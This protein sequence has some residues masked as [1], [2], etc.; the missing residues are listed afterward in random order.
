MKLDLQKSN[1]STKSFTL[2]SNSK[3]KN[4]EIIVNCLGLEQSKIRREKTPNSSLIKNEEKN[5]DEKKI[6]KT[7][8]KSNSNSNVKENDLKFRNKSADTNSR[9][10]FVLFNKSNVGNLKKEIDRYESKNTL[11]NNL[12][13]FSD[14]C[15]EKKTGNF[16]KKINKKEDNISI[17]KIKNFE[18]NE[19]KKNRYIISTDV[20]NKDELDFSR[21]NNLPKCIINLNDSKTG[22]EKGKKYLLFNTMKIFIFI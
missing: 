3:N 19:R 1:K 4:R 5:F 6:K 18:E 8:N 21:G 16:I 13:D 22:Q 11:E 10:C 12:S 15:E 7:L 2:N 9:K 14:F 20:F 17:N